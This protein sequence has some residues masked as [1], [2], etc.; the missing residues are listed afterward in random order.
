MLLLPIAVLGV[1]ATFGMNFGVL[2]P[3]LARD[4]L[5]GGPDLFGFLM[6]ASGIGSLTAALSIAFGVRPTLRLLVTGAAVFGLALVGLALSRSVP[7]SLV[8]MAVLGW[9]LI[10]MAATTN[11]LVQLNVPDELRGRVMSIY[12]TVFAGSTPVG[13]LFSGVIAGLAGAPAALLAGGI[14]STLAAL[15]AAT[16][17]PQLARAA[18]RQTRPRTG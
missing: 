18:A 14:I 12:T 16:R 11:T 1:V 2:M 10:A 7:V 3:V 9:G 15:V 13:G 4:V 5:G 17:V 8:L 6:A